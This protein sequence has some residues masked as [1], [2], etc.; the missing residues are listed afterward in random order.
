MHFFNPVAVLPLV[1]VVRTPATD[2]E[3]LRDGLGR[4][5][6]SRQAWS[7]GRRR[8]RLRRQPAAHAPV[9]GADAGDRGGE[10]VR[11]DGR[12]RAAARPADAARRRCSRW[13]GR[14]WRTT[15]CTRS[16]TR[17]RTVSRSRRRSRRS[18]PASSRRSRSAPTGRRSTRSTPG[19][20]DA[21]ADECA[22]LLDEGVVGSAAEIDACLILGA[23]YPFF[24]GGITRH[25]D[26]AGA[27]ARVTGGR[28]RP[29]DTPRPRPVVPLLS[30][31]RPRSPRRAP[32]A[33]RLLDRGSRRQH[34]RGRCGHAGFDDHPDRHPSERSEAMRADALRAEQW[35]G[36]PFL[37]PGEDPAVALA[38]GTARRA[39]S[40]TPS[41]R[42]A[43]DAARRRRAGR[44]ATG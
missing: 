35:F 15:C 4:D 40:T 20:L 32:R 39:R 37:H 34:L 42:S 23:G 10:L 1:E 21:L 22:R 8:A 17:S 14:R 41:S 24:R 27:S 19:I 12:G 33:G 5:P 44:C 2:D 16:T 25:L 6:T 36:E 26:D 29:A 30:R 11:G 31:R 7:P 38:P 18:P 9:V 43:R 28:S 13:S 3:T